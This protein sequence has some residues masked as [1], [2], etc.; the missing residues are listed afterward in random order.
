MACFSMKLAGVAAALAMC[1]GSTSAVAASSTWSARAPGSIRP[2]VAV[3]TLGSQASRAALCGASV[4][5]AT[6]GG[7]VQGRRGC[8]LPIMDQPIAPVQAVS[9]SAP[10]VTTAPVRSGGFLLPAAAI[11]GF[12]VAGFFVTRDNNSRNNRRPRSP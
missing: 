12:L 5:A 9:Q 1:L 3:S 11:A 10:P 4:S 6:Q 2:L 8:V 7:A